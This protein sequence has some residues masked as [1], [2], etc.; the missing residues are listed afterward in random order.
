MKL[1][2]GEGTLTTCDKEVVAALGQDIAQ[3]IGE[4]R[5]NFWFEGN[6]KFTLEEQAL[7]VGV[8]NLFFQDWLQN[9]F[10]ESVRA[11]AS[12]VLGRPVQVRFAID[13]E[14]FQESRRAQEERLVSGVSERTG[15]GSST[16]VM[17]APSPRG[18]SIEDRASRTLHSG[19]AQEA[20]I[21]AR[22]SILDPPSSPGR[23]SSLNSSRI[24]PKRARRW[25]RLGEFAVGPCNR[26]AHASAMSVVEDPGQGANPLVF[27]GPVGTGKTHLLEGIYV[28]LRKSH[29]EWQVRFVTAEDFTNRFLPA[30]RLGKL[31]IFRKFFRECDAL[32]I[33]DVHFLAGKKATQEEFLHTMDVLVNEGRQLVATCDCHPKL[34]GELTPE[35]IDRLMGGGIWSVALPDSE[36]RLAILRSRCVREEV[37]VPEE[38]L[39]FLA[40]QLRGNVR[41]LEGAM[42]SLAHLRR[43]L[44]RPIDMDLARETLGD[45]LRH[46]LRR[47]QLTDVDRAVCTALRLAPGALQTKHRTWAVSHPRMIAMFLARKHTSAAY[48]EIG[49]YFGGRNHSTA[50]AAEKKTRLWIQ[51]DGELSLGERTLRAREVVEL[52]EREL[53]K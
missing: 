22:S 28:G 20:S 30:M 19:L 33:D 37:A 26:V 21:S 27:H 14:L 42:H 41:E 44:G 31:G 50:V 46:S 51:T 7:T 48:S 47:L 39:R 53:L 8:P 13:P 35:L 16:E 38:V 43:V 32:L 40:Q 18:L 10:G 36:T 15:F 3:R 49:Q 12:E 17:P 45:L 52:A 25:R 23:S 29:P 34:A 2:A 11:A 4:P 9:T 24:A 6:T 5:F 1:R